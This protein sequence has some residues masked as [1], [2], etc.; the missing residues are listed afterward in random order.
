[1][2]LLIVVL[3]FFASSIIRAQS[4]FI[5]YFDFNKYNLTAAGQS[6]LDSFMQVQKN[7]ITA[8]V[9]NLDGHC[10]VI[11][12]DEYN[13]KLSERRVETVKNYLLSK[14]IPAVQIINIKGHGKKVL[15]NEN[16]T[17]AERQLNRRVEINFSKVIV[18]DPPGVT[19]LKEKLA[20]T[21]IKAGSNIVLKNIN[22]VGGRHQ[23]LPEAKPMLDELLEAMQ[24]NPNLV[25]RVEGHI[26]CIENAGDGPDLETGINNLSF[27][28]AKAVRD[29][30][31][32]NNI[33]A[34]RV[35]Y[36][37]FGHSAP[38]YLWPEKN[39]EEQTANRRVEIKIINK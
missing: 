27:A 13:I 2:K 3:T 25:I 8:I 17:A 7:D 38:I 39:A 10:D 11:G 33:A 31:V 29:F 24:T 12:S 14:G 15:V 28:R 20:D 1:M 23:F 37:G 18:T 6:Q 32:A 9:I 19:T 4:S 30:L 26:C 22:F 5:I 16:V 34:E 21:T 36:K 35:S